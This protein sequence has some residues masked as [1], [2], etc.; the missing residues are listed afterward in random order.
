MR[1]REGPGACSLAVCGRSTTFDQSRASRSTYRGASAHHCSS[2]QRD[3]T[4]CVC[5][6]AGHPLQGR[7]RA[8]PGTREALVGQRSRAPVA[9]WRGR[10]EWL[11]T[12]ARRARARTAAQA[13]ASTGARRARASRT[14]AR[15]KN[16]CQHGRRAPQVPVQGLRHGL[17][18]TGSRRARAVTTAPRRARAKTARIDNRQ[19][20]Q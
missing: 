20:S 13:T 5:Y 15:P 7:E 8:W 18:S 17:L 11:S 16:F 1:A 9:S 14:A 6:I 2:E 10:Q 4:I 12:P 3:G 19:N